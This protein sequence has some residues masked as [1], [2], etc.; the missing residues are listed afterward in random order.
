MEKKTIL[1]IS[2]YDEDNQ[3]SGINKK[4][5]N[6]Y[7]ALGKAVKGKVYL[8]TLKSI[9]QTKKISIYQTTNSEIYKNKVDF[10]LNRWNL[11]DNFINQKNIEIIYIRYQHFSSPS[12]IKFLKKNKNKRII[13]EIPTYPYDDEYKNATKLRKTTHLIDKIYRQKIQKYVDKIVTFSTDTK[14][15]DIPCI[16][17]SNGINLEEMKM[18]K[19]INQNKKIR[20]TSVSSCDFW[21]GIDRFLLSL[22]E[23][24][25]KSIKK[26]IL[27]NIVGE[28]A[29]SNKFKDI[30]SKSEYLSKIVVFKGFKSGKELDDIYDETD[31]AVG[32]LGNHRKGIYTIQA[33]KNKE[34]MA[35]GLPMIFSEDDPGL[36]EK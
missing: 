20:F 36:R 29:E 4:I 27:F 26:D 13:L 31:I 30:V 3:F 12:F 7:S 22:E 14:I 21:H 1:F 10:F 8:S 32:C 9:N 34:Y 5:Y 23:Y 15:W 18:V 28:G 33:L 2:S 35:K 19:Y 11:I 24:G 25:K 17:I 16:N 6:Q